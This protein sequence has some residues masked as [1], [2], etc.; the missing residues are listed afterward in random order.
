MYGGLLKFGE[1]MIIQSASTFSY[2]YI[3]SGPLIAI[4]ISMHSGHR[5][6]FSFGCIGS[7][8]IRLIFAHFL[9]YERQHVEQPSSVATL[10]QP[11]QY[12]SLCWSSCPLVPWFDDEYER[13]KPL[14]WI[15]CKN[16]QMTRVIWCTGCSDGSLFSIFAAISSI[17]YLWFAAT[18][19]YQ[20]VQTIAE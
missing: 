20:L 6:S 9:W 13:R 16:L 4:S 7:I 10:W 2:T 11:K 3:L 18:I 17:R 12:W 8:L 14:K 5:H 19:N 1:L 15:F